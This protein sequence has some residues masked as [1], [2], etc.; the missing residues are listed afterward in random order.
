VSDIADSDGM[1][2]AQLQWQISTDSKD[3]VNISGAVQQSFTPREIHFGKYLRVVI[4]Y[5]DG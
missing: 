4:S 1:G 5:V 3:W 2:N